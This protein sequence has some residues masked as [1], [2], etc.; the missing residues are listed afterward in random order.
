LRRHSPADR[1]KYIIPVC[2]YRVTKEKI[3]P[4]VR[5]FNCSFSLLLMETCGLA[6]HLLDDGTSPLLR[7]TIIS[8]ISALDVL[9]YK[10]FTRLLE[11]EMPQLVQ[12]KII[13]GVPNLKCNDPVRPYGTGLGFVLV[14]DFC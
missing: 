5:S 3:V 2:V 4:L 13:F 8:M 11:I 14:P 7:P 10:Q 1:T 9:Q 12:L 6:P